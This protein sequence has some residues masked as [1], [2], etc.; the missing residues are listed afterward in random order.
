MSETDVVDVR[1]LG[2]P[3]DLYRKAKEH[4]DELMR[5]LAL[6][7]LD[8][9]PSTDVPRRLVELIAALRSRY[10]RFTTGADA[11]RDEAM[12]RGEAAV[13]LTYRIP[14]QAR[15]AVLDLAAM[16]DEADEF[17]RR[18]EH[19]LTL[20]SPPDARAFRRWF[21]GEFVAQIDGADPTPWEGQ[22]APAVSGP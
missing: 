9:D 21:L 6:L 10:A 15:T 1:L 11:V 4:H 16:L 19:L 7:A 17:C 3:L 20:A 22:P 13:D 5:E 12:N 14:V 8:D 2:F 18:G